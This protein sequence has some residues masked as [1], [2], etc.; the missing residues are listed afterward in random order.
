M[1]N[2]AQIQEALSELSAL[3][4]YLRQP[5][6]K[7]LA[8][9]RAAE[10]VAT[11][12]TELATVVEQDRLRELP[13][14]GSALSAQIQEL[15][16]T[17]SSRLLERLRSEA[18]P[19]AAELVRVPGL[20]PRRISALSASLGVRSVE[21]LAAACREGRVQTVPGFGAKTEQQLLAACERW[22][23]RSLSQP[24]LPLLL[25]RATE[26]AEQML[27]TLSRAGIR[28][29][30]A[31]ALRRGEE[32]VER[33]DLVVAASVEETTLALRAERRVLRTDAEQKVVYLAERRTAQLHVTSPARWGN[34]WLQATGDAEHVAAVEERARARGFELSE[35]AFED[36]A[37]L[38]AAVELPFVPPELRGR[39]SSRGAALALPDPSELVDVE[40]IRGLVHCHTN[41]SD[42]KHSVLEMARAAHA[43]GMRYIT[44]TDHS[45]S[46]HYAGGVS[47]DALYRQ[48]EEIAQ[49]EELVP[50]RILR[51]TESDI[52]RDGALDYPDHVLEQ[53]DVVIASIHARH[54]QTREEMTER[55]RRALSLPLFKIWGHGLGRILNHRDPIECDVEVVLDAL[56][57]SGGAVELNADPHRLDLPPRWIPH[58]AARGLPFVVSVDAHSVNGFD[59]LRYG[60]TMARRGGLRRSQVLNTLDADEFIARVR[61]TPSS[62]NRT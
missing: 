33:L 19:G 26:L 38:Y 28:A 59:V 31:G 16:N 11:L 62:R 40:S 7:S 37:A 50:I 52:L 12:G 39:P 3:L 24:P 36:E 58:A 60:V 23:Q 61:P 44:I 21:E 6:F 9:E 25:S 17:G 22:T 29:A 51:G 2:A 48:W 30:T 5:K 4:V 18:P 53:L 27:A 1:Q 35:R 56:S 34:A 54:R 13:G 14:I 46:A 20:T 47:V 8:Y 55:L 10:T 42:G 49:A 32:T 43:L 15:Y 57:G 41:Y 45:P